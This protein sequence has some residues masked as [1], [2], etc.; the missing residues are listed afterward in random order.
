M[1]QHGDIDPQT[2]RYF[3]GFW[4]SKEEF[5]EIHHYNIEDNNNEDFD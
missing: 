2:K 1:V 4:M 5:D 3:C